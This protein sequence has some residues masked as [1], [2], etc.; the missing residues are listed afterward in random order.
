MENIR[1]EA[2]EEFCANQHKVDGL[3][4]RPAFIAGYIRASER[5]QWQ[6]IETAPRD[7][8][9]RLYM[10]NGRCVQGFVDATDTL[11][12]QTD[13]QPWRMMHGRP[14]HWM[15]LPKPPKNLG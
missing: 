5:Y 14:T 7:S 3:S 1:I 4:T 2:N 9:E 8:R 10:V 12:V 15:P 6:P 11:C 13:Y